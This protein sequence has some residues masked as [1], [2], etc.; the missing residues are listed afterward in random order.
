LHYLDAVVE[1]FRTLGMEVRIKSKPK[2]EDTAID[3][4]FLKQDTSWNELILED[5]FADWGV[6]QKPHL[7]IKVEVD[8]QPPTGF[9]TEELLL[10][11]P[12]SFY[13]KCFTLPDLFAGKMH[14]LLFRQ[15]KQR[16]KGRDWFDMEWY[17]RKGVPMNLQ[18]FHKRATDS[19]KW[20][21]NAIS[22]T[23]FL[24]ILN[25]KIEMT[26]IDAVKE[27][28]IRFIPDEAPIEIWSKKY[29]HDLVKRMKFS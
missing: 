3:S 27:D 7:R 21:S 26:S 23:A 9:H 28:I 4:A 12:F 15:W 2:A 8:K 5:M 25:K 10:T 13:V 14:A 1:E 18:H 20:P 6:S 29:F 17:I 11:K 19:G 22:E 16:V 24:D